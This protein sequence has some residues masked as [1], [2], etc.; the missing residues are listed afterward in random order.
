M[1]K[2]GSL[3]RLLLL[4]TLLSHNICCLAYDNMELDGLIYGNFYYNTGNGYG[5]I[6]LVGYTSVPEDLTIPSFVDYKYKLTKRNCY[7]ETISYN[8]FKNCTQLKSV[9]I[10]SNYIRNGAFE[11]CTNLHSITINCK[12]ISSK[13]FS[14]CAALDTVYW[15]GNDAPTIE[16]DTFD[17]I[18]YQNAK[19]YVPWSR[20][21]S[22]K[23]NEIW[24]RFKHLKVLY[25]TANIGVTGKGSVNVNY[26]GK[27]MV[28]ANENYVEEGSSALI[29]IVPND[30]Y[31]LASLTVGGI[32]VTSQVKDNQFVIDE[33]S[34]SMGINATFEYTPNTV[35]LS[36]S[37]NGYV[38][39][40]ER[41]NFTS[42]N[43]RTLGSVRKSSRSFN[44]R[45]GFH[46]LFSIYSDDGYQIAK[47][48]ENGTDIT[49]QINNPID[50]KDIAINAKLEI[51]FEKIPAITHKF[52]CKATGNGAIS[53]NGSDIRNSSYTYNVVDGDIIVVDFLPD[54]GSR[55]KS[56]KLDNTDVTSSIVNNQYTI[57]N[58]S[59]DVSIEVEFEA[60]PY[61][62]SV[63]AIGNGT[64]TYDGTE[65]RGKIGTFTVT[66]GSSATILFT[67][68]D[69]YRIESLKLNETDVL[70]GLSNNQYTI[71]NIS[72]DT[73]LEVEFEAIPPT[74]YTLSIKVFGY[75]SASYSNTAIRNTTKTF[76]VNEGTSATIGITPDD[77]YRIKN[78]KKDGTNVTSSVSNG[79][80]TISNIQ[81]NTSVEV[82]FEAITHTL[83]IKAIGNGS[84]S[85]NNTAIRNTTKTFTVNEG[86]SATISI[87]PDDGYRI[88]SVKKDG[89][90]VTSSVSNSKYTVSNIQNDTSIEVEFEAI[91]SAT[92]TLSIK[93]TGYGS[94]S[95]NSNTI[96]N[97]TKAFTVTEGASATINI[98]PDDGYKI[99]TVKKDGTNVTSSVY[100]NKFAATNIQSNTS[101]E[102]EFEAITRTLYIK[103]FGNGYA[104]YNSTTIR[105]TTKTFTINEG[106]SATISITPDDGYKIKSVKNDG[107][108]VT[109]YVSGNK[110]SISNIQSD[111]SVEVEFE[112][113]THSLSIK[114][115]GN[116]VATYDGTNIRN[117][118]T[119]FTV[120]EGSSAVV[121]FTPDNGYQIKSVKLNST[122]I[123]S[124]VYNSQYIISNITADTS[125]EVEFEAIPPTTYTLSIKAIGYGST[126]YNSTTIRNA[127]KSF[128]VNEGT[129]A[130]IGITPDDGYRI[131]SVKKD[132][133]DVTYSVSNN[134]YTVSNIQSDTSVEVEFEN[135]THTLSI[136]ATGN[137]VATYDGTNIRNKTTSFTVNEGSSA[138][139]KFTPDNGCRIKSVKLNSTIVTSSVTNNQ[140]TISNITAD[141]SLEVEFEVI[142][143]TLSIK[144][145]GY[146]AASYNSTTIRNTTKTFTVNEGTSATISFTSDNGYHIRGMAV[147]GIDRTSYISNDQYTVSNIVAN[148]SVEVEFEENVYPNANLLY[149]A[150]AQLATKNAEARK[151]LTTSYADVVSEF[152]ASMN[153]FD[154]DVY[155]LNQWYGSL[156]YSYVRNGVDIPNSETEDMM[157]DINN[158]ST[159]IDKVLADA[160]DKH[161]TLRKEMSDAVDALQEKLNGV[162]KMIYE[163]YE[164][165]TQFDTDI[166][167]IQQD[168][169]TLGEDV[170]ND[171][172]LNSESFEERRK[173]IDGFIDT[174]Q[175]DATAYYQSLFVTLSV[176]TTGNG[177]ASCKGTVIRNTTETFSIRK[178]DSPV[179][180]ISSDNGY[181]IKSVKVNNV[182]HANVESQVTINNIMENTVVEV[183]FEANPTLFVCEGVNYS[184]TSYDDKTVRLAKGNYGKVLEIP[185]TIS[186]MDTEWTLIGVDDDAFDNAEEI[187]AII[188]H[189]EVFFNATI[190]N[191][192]LLL[193]VNNSIYAPNSVN[194]VVVNGIASSITLTDAESGN[195]FY[196]PQEFTAQHIS[197]SHNYKMTTG[198]GIA[199][200]WETIALPFDVQTVMHEEKGEIVP[201]AKWQSGD[202]TKP[203]WLMQLENSG[204]KAADGI[205]ANT[206][207]I[208]SM[209]NNS[210]YKDEF[211]LNGKI[212]F[213]SENVTI[214]KTENMQTASYKGRTFV[215]TYSEEA[216]GSGFYVLNVSNDYETNV[217]GVDDGSHFVLNLRRVHPFEAYMITS[218]N[219][220]RAIDISD[221]M[222]DGI[223]EEEQM[224]MHVYNLKGLMMNTEDGKSME[225]IKRTLPSGVY[226]INGHKMIVK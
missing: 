212:T 44:V 179:I 14:G 170:Q 68:D 93:A 71:S 54:E 188:W 163:E 189:P 113:I 207:Y 134:K 214:R 145:T 15:S 66:H 24:S 80:Y 173:E 124:N 96:R 78:V 208:I 22:F 131:K 201:F 41:Q 198:I 26:T 190:S 91:P 88:K 178:G 20:L 191:P 122:D 217:S 50:S 174:L 64:A 167:K 83:S 209:P 223:A 53:Y 139:V 219:G 168:I 76:T 34:E 6:D 121:Q 77:G 197:Y 210:V 205:K 47:V 75:G 69:G 187:A 4:F 82:E 155:A 192:N 181:H 141:M 172:S 153:S 130:T 25:H 149:T 37:G 112:A 199:K 27:T 16:D 40:E 143:H 102:V 220:T 8:A 103:A 51:S 117:K 13:A 36:V 213:S 196:C 129:S 156:N 73:S 147:D 127:T 56:V 81:S 32:D 120:N 115:I 74:T 136:K 97:A 39:C 132:G 148:I 101:V 206:P 226:I 98:I 105:N 133:A 11:N 118:T 110:Y 12:N 137:G 119:S 7:V 86:T 9:R 166:I 195:N 5:L 49:S 35:E 28:L 203:F 85:Y 67:P 72:V 104:S 57:A 157:A 31:H 70:S 184:V 111:T 65:I 94:V 177:S 218:T 152:E 193:Y 52:T 100:G 225:E 92:Y 60:I 194:N 185:A 165:G 18:T 58:I 215:P 216:M 222:D 142:I 45:E 158:V 90:D 186:Y 30:G 125:L 46:L 107:T 19:V 33:V 59:A 204:W 17:E 21:D 108:N 55:I 2:G 95:Y 164:L 202:S 1:K 87:T 150:L 48:L 144:A 160:K 62:L 221:G 38:V 43:N 3:Y 116:G 175:S 182:Y 128:T 183:E 146:G 138:V 169:N 126:L 99:K 154:A 151:T 23:S 109:S 211:L 114:A 89:T 84:A 123:T 171:M 140:Y 61:T 29:S 176:T 79:K 162:K 63:K 10:P 42:S 159:N 200:G 180:T 135:I 161:D 106:S 224:P